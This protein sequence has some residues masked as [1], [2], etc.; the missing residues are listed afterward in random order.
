MEL[1]QSL[2]LRLPLCA[3]ALTL[4][5]QLLGALVRRKADACIAAAHSAA[6]EAPECF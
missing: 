4:D 3:H 1:L 5:S 2:L 6:Q